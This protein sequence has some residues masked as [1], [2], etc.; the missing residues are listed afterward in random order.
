MQDECHY[1]GLDLLHLLEQVGVGPADRKLV[2]KVFEPYVERARE[3]ARLT[4]TAS[5][6]GMLR[7]RLA[8]K[9]SNMGFLRNHFLSWKP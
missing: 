2:R 6:W 3:R 9:H 4:R 5:I 7:Y 8:P 1:G